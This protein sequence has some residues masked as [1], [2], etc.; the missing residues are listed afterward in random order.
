M[1]GKWKGRTTDKKLLAG[2]TIEGPKVSQQYE[3]P[4]QKFRRCLAIEPA[5]AFVEGW[6]LSSR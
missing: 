1:F 5:V 2:T 4:K 6:T 3:N